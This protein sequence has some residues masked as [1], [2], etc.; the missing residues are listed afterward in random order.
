VRRLAAALNR[1]GPLV[2]ALQAPKCVMGPGTGLGAAQL[3]WDTGKEAY[4]VVPGGA[5]GAG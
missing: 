3:F 5:D 1:L 4:T 2:P